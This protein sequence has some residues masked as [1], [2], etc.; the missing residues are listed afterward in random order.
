MP[1]NW[2]QCSDLILQ[3][4]T[5]PSLPVFQS[6]LRLPD[7]LVVALVFYSFLVAVT[8]AAASLDERTW[9]SLLSFHLRQRMLFTDQISKSPLFWFFVKISHGMSL[10]LGLS[11]TA[12]FVDLFATLLHKS[13][14]VF[15]LSMNKTFIEKWFTHVCHY[16]GTY[17]R[18]RINYGITNANFEK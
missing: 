15:W 3:I 6:T 14:E 16:I 9:I 11:F 7:L 17:R 8:L 5:P 18:I 10:L 1:H 13:R 2:K 4:H 12:I